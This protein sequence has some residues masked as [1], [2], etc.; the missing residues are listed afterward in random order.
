MKPMSQ[1]ELDELMRQIGVPKPVVLPPQ[2]RDEDMPTIAEMVRDLD[3][4]AE[5]DDNDEEEEEKAGWINC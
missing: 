3:A 5:E 4:V 1:E 2:I